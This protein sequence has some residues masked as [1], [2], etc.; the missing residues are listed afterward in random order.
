MNLMTI[1]STEDR[2]FDKPQLLLATHGIALTW[3][4]VRELVVTNGD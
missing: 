1:I 2:N 4:E 3:R